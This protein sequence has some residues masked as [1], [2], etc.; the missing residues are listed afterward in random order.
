[1]KYN[2]YENLEQRTWVFVDVETTGLSAVT[3]DAV[4]EVGVVKL[5][6]N[7]IIDQFSSLINPQRAIPSEVSRIHGIYDKDVAGQPTFNGIAEKFGAFLTDSIFCGYNVGFDL[8]FINNELFRSD[9]PLLN[10]PVVDILIMARKVLPGRERYNLA[11]VAG[12]LNLETERFHRALDDAMVTVKIFQKLRD[13]LI[14]EGATRNSDIVSLYG[15]DNEY[16]QQIHEPK[17]F[18]I[19]ECLTAKAKVKVTYLSDNNIRVQEVLVP[20]KINE[21]KG[22]GFVGILPDTKDQRKVSIKKILD[23]EVF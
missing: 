14:I 19:K 4:C 13:I 17:M 11:S 16:L 2:K 12:Y 20:T 23:L 15:V 10:L 18:F 7:T 3:G 9:R 5:K 8:G 22:A 21:G 6:D 1:M